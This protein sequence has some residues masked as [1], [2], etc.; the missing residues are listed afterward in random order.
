MYED[1]VKIAPMMEKQDLL[2]NNSLW[3]MLNYELYTILDT[4]LFDRYLTSK[5][6]GWIE[7]NSS[8]MEFSSSFQLLQNKHGL[9]LSEK[10]VDT[11]KCDVLNF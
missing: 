7:V 3:Y 2:G 1:P 6:E 11:L 5:W 8:I 9:M 4:K 10:M